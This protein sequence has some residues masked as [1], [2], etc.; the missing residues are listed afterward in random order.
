MLIE[1]NKY[2]NSGGGETTDDDDLSSTAGS[3]AGMKRSNYP[4]DSMAS[5]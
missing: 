3:E 4:L 5:F 2:R 1:T